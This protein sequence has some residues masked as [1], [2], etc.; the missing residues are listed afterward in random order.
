MGASRQVRYTVS[1]GRGALLPPDALQ[2]DGN[3]NAVF[4]AA[5]NVAER[6]NVTVIGESGGRV[7]VS[8]LPSGA[9]VIYPAP[10]SLQSGAAISVQAT[11]GESGK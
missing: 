1:L 2:T 3:G 4:L 11:A 6:Q 9:R 8:G 10:P 5:E 7:A